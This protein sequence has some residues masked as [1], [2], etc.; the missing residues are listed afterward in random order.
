MTMKIRTFALATAAALFVAGSAFAQS[1]GT[2]SAGSTGQNGIQSP[3]GAATG[4]DTQNNGASGMTTGSTSNGMYKSDEEKMM[5]QDNAKMM[6]PF[7][8]DEAMTELKSKSEIQETFNAMDSA[9]Q[10]GMK[11]SCEKA[12][13]KRGSYGSVT[14][15]LCSSIGVM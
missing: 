1:G 4:S 7:F 14:S 11:S 5:Y 3:M 15:T 13:E 9:S 12:G 2:G 10:A 6:R 8:K